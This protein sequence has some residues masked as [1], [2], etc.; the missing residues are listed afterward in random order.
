MEN[1]KEAVTSEEVYKLRNAVEFM[2]ALS[3]ESFSEIRSIALLALLSL[4]TPE[5]HKHLENVA[6]ALHAIWSKADQIKESINFHAEEVGCG[7]V[8]DS[9]YRRHVAY[10]KSRVD[11]YA[12]LPP[13]HDSKAEEKQP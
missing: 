8:D 7:Y 12:G 4:E 1:T 5:G 13:L 9:R 3:Q 6:Q 2:D 10:M 11:N